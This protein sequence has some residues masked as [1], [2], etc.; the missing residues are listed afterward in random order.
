MDAGL[1]NV[2]NARFCRLIKY[3][4]HTENDT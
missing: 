4:N 3:L 2:L 1:P